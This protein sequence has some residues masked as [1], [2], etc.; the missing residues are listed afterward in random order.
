MASVRYGDAFAERFCGGKGS[1]R[2]SERAQER[3][4]EREAEEER[5]G[6][7]TVLVLTRND[8][9]LRRLRHGIAWPGGIDR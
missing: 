6:S 1:S 4:E 7:S 2:R 8:G 9:G 5:W 3:G